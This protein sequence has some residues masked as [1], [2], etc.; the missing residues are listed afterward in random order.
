[1]VH[2][3][4]ASFQ[5]GV[6]AHAFLAFTCCFLCVLPCMLDTEGSDADPSICSFAGICSALTSLC[7]SL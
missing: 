5:N 6:M 1:M 2:A 3:A 7:C 4:F